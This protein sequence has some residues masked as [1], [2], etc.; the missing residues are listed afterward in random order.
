MYIWQL[1]Q[2]TSIEVEKM[3]K[4]ALPWSSSASVQ[5]ES[6]RKR[7]FRDDMIRV[8]HRAA[9]RQFA[10]SLKCRDSAESP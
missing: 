6:K 2:W 3:A 9:A 4:P 1:R 7:Q 8:A 10:N 5:N